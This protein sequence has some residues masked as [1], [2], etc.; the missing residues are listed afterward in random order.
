MAGIH[1]GQK[2]SG[3]T[4]F[5]FPTKSFGNDELNAFVSR[6]AVSWDFGPMGVDKNG[7]G[8]FLGGEKFI[9]DVGVN[10]GN[11]SEVRLRTLD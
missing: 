7:V 9:L 11:T 3:M 10:F 1:S 6:T 4:R 8:L 5:G 2:H